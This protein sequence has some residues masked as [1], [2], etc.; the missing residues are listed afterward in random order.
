MTAAAAIAAA[1]ARDPLAS[2]SLTGPQD[3]WVRM[4]GP[5]DP[6]ADGRPLLWLGAN[7]IG[8]S[9]AQAVKLLHFLRRTG[10]YATRRPGPVQVTIVSISKEQIVPL[11]EKLWD[12]LPK[13]VV[14]GE[15][16]P[17]ECPGARFEPGFGFRGKPPRLNFR[18]GAAAGSLVSFATY[19]QGSTRIAGATLDVLMLDEPPPE[20]MWSEVVLRMIRK[21]GQIW[22]SMTITPESPPQEWMRLKVEAGEVRFLHTPMT[23][24]AVR[25]VDGTPPFLSARQIREARAQCSE[26]ERPLRFD[27]AWD[28]AVV[29]RWLSAWGPWCVSDER[30]PAGARV[31]VS[32]DHSTAPG[33]QVSLLMACLPGPPGRPQ[34]ARFWLLDE[35]SPDPN[36]PEK[37]SNREAAQGIVD[38]LGRQ[39]MTWRHV[40]VWLGDRAAVQR[41]D[42]QVRA[43]NAALRR[44]IADIVGSNLGTFPRIE[45]PYKAS[46]TVAA[47]FGEMNSRMAGGV[48]WKVSPRCRRFIKSADTWNGQRTAKEK[49]LLDCAR[50]GMETALGG[51]GWHKAQKLHRI[52]T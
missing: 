8:K 31:I 22:I 5:L 18:S 47:G 50:Y 11:M 26:A 6:D 48:G 4:G 43:D 15:A 40:D 1:W 49:D 25:P 17:I 52:A 16:R 33:R 46:G 7:Q 36:Q 37:T 34:D 21:G 19:K 24:A 2:L 42:K 3:E 41:T 32:V 10:P 14:D 30:P 28:G 51:K 29:E 12:L 20:S 44:L 9:Y 23:V 27:A 13:E 39:G 38:M 35:H 45:V